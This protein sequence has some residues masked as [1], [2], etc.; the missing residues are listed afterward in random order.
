M[1]LSSLAAMTSCEKEI[2][3]PNVIFIYADDMGKGMLSAFGQKYLQTPNIDKLFNNG[4]QFDNTYGGHFSAPAR[5]MLLTGY[6][7][8]RADHWNISGAG[9]LKISDTTKIASIEDRINKSRVSLADND[10]YLAQIFQ[11]AGYVTGQVGK[12]GYSFTSTRADMD[13]QGWDFYYGYLDHG[14]CHGFFPP[15]LFNTGEIEMIEGNTRT[16][17]AKA[18]EP[19]D[20]AGRTEDRMDMTGKAQYSQDIFNAKIKEFLTENKDRPFFLYHPTQ[21]PHGPLSVPALH[22]QVKDLDELTHGEKEYATM[23]ILLDEAVGMIMDELEALGIAD[24]TMII[25]S[26]DNGHEVYTQT[27]ASNRTSKTHDLVQGKVIDNLT[28]KYRSDVCGDIFDGNM[29]LAGIK[30]SNLNGGITVP[31]TYYMPGTIKPGVV[32][33]IV[34][35]YD[36]CATMAEMLGVEIISAKDSRSYYS[37]LKDPNSHLPSDRVIVIDSFEG[38]MIARNDGWKVRYSPKSKGFELYNLFEDKAEYNNRAAE[39]P[40]ILEEL[41]VELQSWDEQTSCRGVYV[42]E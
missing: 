28:V 3:Q 20:I 8:C 23:M 26:A 36:M 4:L 22:N 1:A 12:L 40:E 16:D 33:D 34:A 11:K 18:L 13:R 19:Y 31:L 32:T 24:N 37:V 42:N 38:P 9:Q 27:G 29:G 41:R 6:S 2:E 30:R 7:D 14:R 25:F 15:V 21:L 17:C 39:Y 35:N 10:E 5:A